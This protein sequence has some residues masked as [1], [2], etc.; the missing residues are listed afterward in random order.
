MQNRALRLSLGITRDTFRVFSYCFPSLL[1]AHVSGL[2]VWITHKTQEVMDSE[3]LWDFPR[4]IVTNRSCHE[5]N[6]S[7][8]KRMPCSTQH[9]L[10]PRQQKHQVSFEYFIVKQNDTELITYPSQH[11][12]AWNTKPSCKCQ[13]HLSCKLVLSSLAIWHPS[14]NTLPADRAIW[15]LSLIHI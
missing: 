6:L 2:C 8:N 4:A 15:L 13:R 1:L 5:T 10:L 3:I 14:S 9:H 11:L 12:M 7:N